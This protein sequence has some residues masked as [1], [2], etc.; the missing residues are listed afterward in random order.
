[1]SPEI[2]EEEAYQ[3]FVSECVKHCNC[4]VNQPCDGVLAG[5][6]CDRQKATP[7]DRDWHCD[8]DRESG[9]AS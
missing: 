8:E 2:S 5:G 6:P 1:V 4:E 7:D 3:K 9:G